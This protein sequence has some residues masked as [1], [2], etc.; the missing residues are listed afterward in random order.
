[1]ASRKPLTRSRILR[2]AMAVA[3]R[4]GLA[5]VTM[6]NVADGLDVEAM[7]LYRHV[8]GKNDLLDS[9]VEVIVEQINAAC[10]A[11]PPPAP[12]DDW[13]RILRRRIL[14]AR[15]TLLQHP[16][17]PALL[18]SHGTMGPALM[19]YFEEFGTIMRRGGFSVDAV[20]HALHAFGSRG[21]GFSSEL[22]Q[23]GSPAIEETE[24]DP[25]RALAEFAAFSESMPFLAE[26]VT[27][28]QHDA[29]TTLSWCDD[30][31]EF[32]FGLDV[33]LDGLELR[34]TR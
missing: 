4:L 3:D 7:A 32:E 12:D 30:Q 34:R 25:E 24:A 21:L 8:S 20:H 15:A 11:L 27:Q 18:G 19:Q 16:W 14:T 29:S 6:R 28:L 22:F 23:P 26:M 10:A 1:M 9:L 13:R 2:E 5:G 33:L 17:A 31:E